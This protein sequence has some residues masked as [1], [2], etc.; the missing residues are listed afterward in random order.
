[1]A[2]FLT[3]AWLELQHEAASDLAPEPGVSA[4][5]QH[6]VTGAPD[7]NVVYTVTYEE[8]QLARAALGPA[9][10]E[11]DLVFTLTYDGARRV[12]RGDLEVGAAFMQG[13]LKV[14]GSM[15]KLLPL[16]RRMH[17]PDHRAMVEKAAAGTDF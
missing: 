15:A 2:G 13:T 5:V 17:R 8:G 4:T 14:E 7:G 16:I 11:P 9:G 3:P 6:V 10:A 1:M 12:A